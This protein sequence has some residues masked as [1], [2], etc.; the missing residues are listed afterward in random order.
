[1]IV[2][3]RVRRLFYVYTVLE[4]YIKDNRYWSVG[5]PVEERNHGWGGH[6]ARFTAT[7]FRGISS[8]P[9]RAAGCTA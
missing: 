7:G 2:P 1:M 6:R 3:L 5:R 4:Y 9:A 8:D